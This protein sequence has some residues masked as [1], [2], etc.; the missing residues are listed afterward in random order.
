MYRPHH[1]SYAG[2]T[3][4]AALLMV[5]G[6]ASASS[7][8]WSDLL[9]QGSLT[10]DSRLRVERAEQTPLEDATAATLSTRVGWISGQYAGF[11]LRMEGE[12][13]EPLG[14]VSYN[15]TT[16]GRLGD[17]VIA[18][19]DATELNQAYVGYD[20]GPVHMQYGRMVVEL[21]NERFV[22]DVGFRQNQQTYDGFMVDAAPADGHRVRYL[23]MT[24]AHRFLGDDHPV[25]EFDMRGHLLHYEHARL[26]ADKLT[27]YGYFIEMRNRGLTGRSHKVFGI[28]YDGSVDVGRTT[29]IYTVEVASQSDHADGNPDN[30]AYY[31]RI[32]GGLRFANAW[33]VGLGVERLSGD[34][35]YGFQTPL[36]TGHAFNGYADVFAAGTPAAGL[37]DRFVTLRLPI[38]GATLEFRYHDFV[39]DE[40][41][42]DYGRELDANILYSFS[43]RWQL[44]M[45]WAD[46]RA[47]D[48]ATD[49]RRLWGWVRFSL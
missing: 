43:E 4:P 24:R 8:E 33:F 47:D 6:A 39:S 10:L 7:A 28:R 23:Y 32:D 38:G 37:D 36:A 14:S 2:R 17:A 40:G 31:G 30:H 49:R 21:G 18:D 13:V 1:R 46:Y 48:F 5:L 26:N 41:S 15:D 45:Q 35:D 42:V 20:A 11:Q 27:A 19:P 3:L 9:T 44:G 12:H 34:G 22:G 25:G 29:A 16:N